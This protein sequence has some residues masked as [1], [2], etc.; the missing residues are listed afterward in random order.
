MGYGPTAEALR[1]GY[2]VTASDI[3]SGT[4]SYGVAG[5]RGNGMSDFD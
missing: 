5:K 4:P 3:D 1:E 2:D